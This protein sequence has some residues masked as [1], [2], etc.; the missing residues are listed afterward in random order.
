MKYCANNKI[1]KKQTQVICVVLGN[2]DKFMNLMY[3][4]KCIVSYIY[5]L[6]EVII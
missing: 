4:K 6:L 5:L 3:N 1:F 2:I